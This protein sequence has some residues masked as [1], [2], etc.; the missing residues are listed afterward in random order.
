MLK[1]TLL[2]FLTYQPMTGYDLKHRM[3]SSTV[4]FWHAELSQIYT[5]LK[6]L[7]KENLVSSS[8]QTQNDRPDKRIYTITSSGINNFQRWLSDPVLELSPK[9]ETII[10]K[11]FFA[12]QLDKNS[13]L[14]QLHLQVD[15]H[16]KQVLYFKETTSR[17]VQKTITEFPTLTRDALF[18]EATRRFGQEYEELY[19]KWLEE[20]IQLVEEKF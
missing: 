15:L 11:L 9:K 17:M 5:T 13:L 8:I 4:H 2:G 18:W 6:S 19:V 3:D 1:Y 16:Q 12:A 10:L 14:S 20:C 7:E